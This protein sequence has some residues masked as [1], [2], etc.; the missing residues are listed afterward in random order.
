MRFPPGVAGPRGGSGLSPA[1]KI[2]AIFPKHR[3]GQAGAGMVESG[4]HGLG[5]RACNVVIDMS[6]TGPDTDTPPRR[7]QK[8]RRLSD[9]VLMAF[10]TA[11]D[12]GDL[13]VAD[14]LLGILELMLRRG[15]P[16]GRAERRVDAQ[17]LVAAHERLWALRHP[18]AND[19]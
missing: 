5:C 11:C 14:E 15:P 17:P 2:G 8:R 12:R 4:R 19:D 10:H 16:A 9:M 3:L 6:D 18:E 1:G 7:S 13:E